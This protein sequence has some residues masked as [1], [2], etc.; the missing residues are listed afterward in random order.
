M[1][2]V[3]KVDSIQNSAGTAAMTIDSSGRV[4]TPS[5][6]MMSVRGVGNNALNSN[7]FASFMEITG[8]STIDVNVGN[9]LQNGRFRVPVT[10]VYHLSVFSHKGTST[11]YRWCG[12]YLYNG[13]TYTQ[14]FSSY[15]FN[16]YDE[17]TLGTSFLKPLNANDEILVGWDNGY[18]NW[19]TSAD[20]SSFTGYLVS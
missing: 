13:S 12:M 2:S 8:W 9:C 6:P 15:S 16:D 19:N 14:L 17:Y 20:N 3:L 1:T 11:D 7:A 10:G 5:K 4:F 18:S